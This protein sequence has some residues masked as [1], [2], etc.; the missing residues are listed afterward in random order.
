MSSGA[1][2][3]DILMATL[4]Q[5]V[6]RKKMGRGVRIRHKKTWRR[7]APGFIIGFLET[8]RFSSGR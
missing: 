1:M 5:N 7:M 8:G 3:I 2:R 6:E 4:W